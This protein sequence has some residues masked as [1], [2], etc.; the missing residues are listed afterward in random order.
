MTEGIKF[1]EE[2]DADDYAIKLADIVK[3]YEGKGYSVEIKPEIVTETR[4]DKVT[5][6]CTGDVPHYCALVIAKKE[7][8]KGK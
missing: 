3:E 1:I 2:L 7:V 6:K 4:Y 5:G 8:T